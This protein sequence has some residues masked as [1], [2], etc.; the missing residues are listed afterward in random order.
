ML[1]V[2]MKQ[3]ESLI[4]PLRTVAPATEAEK[5]ETGEKDKY[6]DQP[7]GNGHRLKVPSF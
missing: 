1:A 5:E 4:A 3:T 7:H 6:D 2:I